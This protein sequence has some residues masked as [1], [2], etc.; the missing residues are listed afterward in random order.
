V[1]A[2]DT[3]VFL[4]EEH[5][6]INKIVSVFSL[7]DSFPGLHE[8]SPRHNATDVLRI[9]WACMHVLVFGEQG[10]A[11]ALVCCRNKLARFVVDEAHCVSTWGHDFR[12]VALAATGPLQPPPV[13]DIIESPSSAQHYSISRRPF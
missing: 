4:E 12:Y 7:S 5:Y 9:E 10:K 6:C 8:G 13:L 2:Y 3:V 1:H 11:Y